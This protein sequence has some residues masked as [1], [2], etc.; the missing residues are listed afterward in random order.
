VN[1]S[2]P[3]A[4]RVHDALVANHRTNAE[5]DGTEDPYP[6]GRVLHRHPKFLG[7]R[8]RLLLIILAGVFSL[9][10]VFELRDQLIDVV[11]KGRTLLVSELIPS[12]PSCPWL[13]LKMSIRDAGVGDVAL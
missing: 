2:K 8:L 11:T 13:S 6:P 9:F 7:K 12:R 10:D 3:L 1:F 4:E 5:A